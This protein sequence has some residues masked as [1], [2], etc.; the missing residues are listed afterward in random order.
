MKITKILDWLLRFG[1]ALVVA[2]GLIY[3]RLAVID[4]RVNPTEV[5]RWLWTFSAGGGVLFA[6]INLR[7]VLIDD[8]VVSQIRTRPVDLLRLQTHSDIGQHALILGALAADFVA[9]VFAILGISIGALVALIMSA[10]ALIA[11]SFTQTQR[12]KR[13]FDAVRF[14]PPK[15]EGA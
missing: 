5:I 6:L 9:G 2:F 14:R 10:A 15:P 11:L 12:R 13:I 4:S 7:E 8:R 1:A 3:L